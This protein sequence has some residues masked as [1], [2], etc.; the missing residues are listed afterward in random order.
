MNP[1]RDKNEGKYS[2]E[3]REDTCHQP[4]LDH[5]RSLKVKNLLDTK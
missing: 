4:Q 2:R 1:K 3:G 5:N